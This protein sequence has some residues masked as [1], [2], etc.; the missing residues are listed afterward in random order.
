MGN[1]I[2]GYNESVIVFYSHIEFGCKVILKILEKNFPQEVD[3]TKAPIRIFSMGNSCIY[4]KYTH[5]SRPFLIT[6]IRHPEV[7]PMYCI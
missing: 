1:I 4:V 6:C 7:V 3:I 2:L 5:Y